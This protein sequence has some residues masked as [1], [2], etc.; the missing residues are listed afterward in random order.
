MLEVYE[1]FMLFISVR[2]LVCFK[3]RIYISVLFLCEIVPSLFVY[4][5]CV[6]KCGEFCMEITLGKDCAMSVQVFYMV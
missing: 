1:C 3:C 4:I 2:L 6:E 5:N